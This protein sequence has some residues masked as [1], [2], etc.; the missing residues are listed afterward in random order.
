MCWVVFF[1]PHSSLG[2]RESKDLF[3]EDIGSVATGQT[4]GIDVISFPAFGVVPK[5]PIE[6]LQIIGIFMSCALDQIHAS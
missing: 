1:F 2:P 5:L 6:K 3:F 4:V